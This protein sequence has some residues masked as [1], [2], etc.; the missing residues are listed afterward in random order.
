M[1]DGVRILDLGWVLG[2][3]F[4]GQ[5]LAQLGAEVIKIESLEGDLARRFPPYFFEGDSAFYLSVNR[6]KSAIALDLKQ[7]DGRAVFADLVRRSDAVIYGFAP[8]V[9]PRLGLDFATLSRI[10][11]RI[12]VGALIGLHDAP[13]YDAAPS[14][15]TIA[16][17]LA[18]V[19]TITGEKDG[20][21]ARV[22]YQVADLV[23]GL[24]LALAVVGALVKAGRAGQGSYAQ[25]S[26]LDG[27]LAM[28]TWQAQNYFVSGEVP[29]ALGSRHATIAPSEA[30]RCADGRWIVITAATDRFWLP[31]C[32]A[33]GRPDL[34]GDPRFIDAAARTANVAALSGELGRAF[35][36]RG[37]DDWAERLFAARVP[38]GKAN[39]V[40]EALAQP[41]ADL[42]HMV[43][44]VARP[45]SGS[46]MRFLG[47]P[48]KFAGSRPL[49]YP[50]AL[51]QDTRRLL[52]G[53]CGYDHARID[54][55]VAA[56]S[57]FC[58]VPEKPPA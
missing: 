6:G 10:N 58:A 30:F 16:Q 53:L 1:L 2:G 39:A 41:L 50:P 27:Q 32:Q 18:G 17:A 19:M 31:L 49:S 33:I 38:A 3:P 57:V 51:G 5:T 35:L 29:R 54:A 47:N 4:A 56:G 28:L 40:D 11:P 14:F 44:T 26:L 9:P 52:H 20:P 43:E 23:G 24:Y 34:A 22:G 8:D 37:A 7:A 42:R 25:I 21:P 45:G 55:L 13:P 36:Q 48:I 15:D 12:C 46:P